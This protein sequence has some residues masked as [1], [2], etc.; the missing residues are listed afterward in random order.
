M[1]QKSSVPQAVS[2]VSQ[3]LKRDSHDQCSHRRDSRK[4]FGLNRRSVS[5]PPSSRAMRDT[6]NLSPAGPTHW[7]GL[8]LPRDFRV[9]T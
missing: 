7:S 8:Y 6:V 4:S 5:I 3:V 2:F 1:S 9:L